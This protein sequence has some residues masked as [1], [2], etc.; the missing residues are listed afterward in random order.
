MKIHTYLIVIFFT[1]L[2]TGS[3][4]AQKSSVRFK[5]I[6]PQQQKLF[7]EQIE[8]NIKNLG[9][10]LRVLSNEEN[11]TVQKNIIAA[12]LDYFI[13]GAKF[14]TGTINKRDKKIVKKEYSVTNYLTNIVANYKKSDIE[15]IDIEF[16]SFEVGNK[17][18]PVKGKLNEYYFEFTFTQI[19]RRGKI[20]KK[21]NAEG[22]SDIEY[23]YVD[24]TKKKGR[25][26][27]KKKNTVL[28]SKWKLYFGDILVED[29]KI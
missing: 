28:G 25:V 5:E 7:K 18:I 23:S 27:V 26:Y 12:Q 8:E 6:T 14:Q 10:R 13:E 29:V 15:I 19:F 21:K 20:G 16:A 24:T 9:Y 11:K 17:L 22:I 3:A 2:N 4:L 1:L